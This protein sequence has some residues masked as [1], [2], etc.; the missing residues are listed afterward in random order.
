MPYP[1]PAAVAVVIRNDSV[2]LASRAN[3][4]HAG[5]WGFPGGKIEIGETI[6][7]AAVREL[8]EETAVTARA[9]RVLTAIDVHIRDAQG[10][11]LRHFV[12]VA[13]LCEWLSGEP[14]AADDARDAAWFRLEGLEQ[15][16][17]DLNPH[18]ARIALEASEAMR[19]EAARPPSR[20]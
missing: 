2:L 15:A 3:P 8:M 18:V 10:R 13:V 1:I 19:R 4:P 20:R 11:L 14:V 7:A 9:C 6:E 5:R 16:G 17:L 12:L